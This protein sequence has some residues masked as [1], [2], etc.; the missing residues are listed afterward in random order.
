VPVEIAS[1]KTETAARTLRPKVQRLVDDYLV[2]L[3]PTPL[4]R[5]SLVLKHDGEDLDLGDL[6][7]L[8]AN[9][10]LDRTVPPVSLFRG[11]TSAAKAQLE[12]FLR[13]QLD[14]YAGH[15]SRPETGDVSHMSKY[16][17]FGQVSPI[18]VALRVREAARHDEDRASY[19]EELIVRREL[20]YNFVNFTGDYDRYSCL[21][22]WA[23][24]TLAEHCRDDRRHVYTEAQL[25]DAATHDPYWNAAMR[26]MRHT[27][28]MHNYMRMYW[29]KKILEWS[30]TPETAYR[31]ALRLNNR[32]FLDGRDP[33]SYANV[34]WLFG[35]HDRPWPGRPVY[36]TV[37]SMSAGGL[38]RKADMPGY[39]A[40]VDEL[41]RRIE[42]RRS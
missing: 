11:G 37:R 2:A 42:P 5:D 8:L 16:L 4:E 33:A 21:P 28:Y 12:E 35:L 6:D 3:R 19:L 34:G 1:S 13:H 38:E 24:A 15:R 31:L 9:L 20:A 32:Y 30:R 23:R 7:A 29:G 10:K 22:E 27:G 26:E 14:G 17:H 41:V 39:I 18:Y 40:R 36:G 25:D